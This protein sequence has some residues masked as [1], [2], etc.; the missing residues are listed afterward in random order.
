LIQKITRLESELQNIKEKS[1]AALLNSV[2][3]KEKEE[4]KRNISDLITRIDFHLSAERQ[5]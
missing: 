1:G 4:L 2:D 3:E 5:A